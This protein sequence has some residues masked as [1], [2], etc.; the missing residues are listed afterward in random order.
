MKEKIKNYLRTKV[1]TNEDL[2]LSKNIKL[3]EVVGFQ[4]MKKFEEA[5]VFITGYPKSGN[6]LLQFTIAFLVYGLRK[7]APYS[8]LNTC[9][10]DVYANPYFTRLNIPH[11]FKSHE[12]PN[13]QYKKVIYVVRDGRDAVRS[14]YYMRKNMGEENVC[15]N[16]MYENGGDCFVGTW[17]DHVKRWIDNPFNADILFIKYEDFITQKEQE[18]K[19]LCQFLNIERSNTEIQQ[20][21][22][23]SSFENMKL[24]EQG[25][26]WKHAKNSQNWKK[27]GSFVREGKSNNF[28]K[29]ENVSAEALKKF[30]TSSS[31]MLKYFKYI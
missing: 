2:N 19:R 1:L 25:Y 26:S 21:I 14:Y 13:E 7:D 29:T 4:K 30:V 9:V 24:L 3:L 23:A 11:C 10:T 12:L 15:I 17:K 18:I 8:L 27:E 20:V 31:E 22:E 28:T 5:D 6:T 16:E